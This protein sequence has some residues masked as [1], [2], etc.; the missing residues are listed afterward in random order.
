V[1]VLSNNGTF[2]SGATSYQIAEIY[3]SDRMAPRETASAGK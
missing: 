3:L 2:N 1:I